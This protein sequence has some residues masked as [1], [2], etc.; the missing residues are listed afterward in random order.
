MGRVSDALQVK[1]RRQVRAVERRV[2]SAQRRTLER[3]LGGVDVSGWG[4][5]EDRGID[6]RDQAAYGY[7]PWLPIRAALRRLE[8]GPQDV[9]VDLGA[10]KGQA[11]LVAAQLP[12]GRVIGVEIA[13]DWSA[14]AQANMER[15]LP[16]LRCRD[17][18]IDTSDVLEWPIPDDLTVVYQYCP[19]IGSVFH[20]SLERLFESLDR[21]PRRM[22][23][24]YNYPWEHNA[25]LATGR[26]TVIDVRPSLWPTRPRWWTSPHV[27]VTYELHAEGA[28]PPAR[29]APDRRAWPQ[30]MDRWA[31]P[32]DTVFVWEYPG[33]DEPPLY[34]NAPRD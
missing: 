18:R 20:G 2:H 13:E 8:P 21:N 34:S 1:L 4:F 9:F 12:F 3:R 33:R 6:K 22:R 32:N 27:I 5:L 30:A 7:S 29:L 17:V 26:A 11:V 19:F 25:L 16:R 28:P 31:R 24:V 14:A 15:A 10:G 23:L